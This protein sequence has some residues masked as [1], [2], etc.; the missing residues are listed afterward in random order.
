MT[1]Y[2]S[3]TETATVT[4]RLDKEKLD[5]LDDK[6]L[7]MKYEGELDRDTTRSDVIKD[8]VDEWLQ[9]VEDR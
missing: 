9:E 3:Q 4:F 7:E 1:V 5:R 8:V 2:M 6:I